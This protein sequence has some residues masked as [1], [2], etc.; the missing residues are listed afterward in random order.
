[1]LTFQ[2]VTVC[3]GATR[4]VDAV[5][6]SVG[7]GEF[8]VLT[9]SNGSGKSSLARARPDGSGPGANRQRLGWVVA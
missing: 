4:A 1:V 5:S 2:E 3:Y 7:A 8:A 9:G 6:L